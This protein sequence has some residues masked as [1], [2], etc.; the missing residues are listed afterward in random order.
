MPRDIKRQSKRLRTKWL[1]SLFPPLLELL[2]SCL[3]YTSSFA[4]LPASSLQLFEISFVVSFI[5]LASLWNLYTKLI[6]GGI[7][8]ILLLFFP[9]GKLVISCFSGLIFGQALQNDQMWMLTF[10]IMIVL[11]LF[12]ILSLK[13]KLNFYLLTILGIVLYLIA[14]T[15]GNINTVALFG[16][17]FV[18]TVLLISNNFVKKHGSKDGFGSYRCV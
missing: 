7:V 9:I 4:L 8:I 5:G 14:V 11:S 6:G 10:V 2:S 12:T 1:A 17:L 3:L 15:Q 16:F 18:I 13:H